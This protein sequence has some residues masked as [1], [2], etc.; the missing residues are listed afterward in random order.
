MLGDRFVTMY[1]RPSG[2]NASRRS[3]HVPVP[4]AYVFCG[5]TSPPVVTSASCSA[6]CRLSSVTPSLY[7]PAPSTVNSMRSSADGLG[8]AEAPGDASPLGDGD[9]GAGAA[10]GCGSEPQPAT[11]RTSTA[12]TRADRRV[13]I[14][15]APDRGRWCKHAHDTARTQTYVI[16]QLS[17][18]ELPWAQLSWAQ[19][20]LLGDE[21]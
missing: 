2:R 10:G 12:A 20:S 5:H 19:R 21:R 16:A 15:S 8:E 3:V 7:G 4:R 17:W 9:V 14:P 6:A 18:A 13:T 11:A 1:S